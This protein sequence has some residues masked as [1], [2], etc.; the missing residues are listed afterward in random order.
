[1]S[2]ALIKESRLHVE[3]VQL[4]GQLKKQ[5]LLIQQLEEE[6]SRDSLTEL[7]TRENFMVAAQHQLATER[8]HGWSMLVF[9]D[10]RDFSTVN[11][12]YGHLV[13]NQIIA[14]IG[15]LLRSQIRLSDRDFHCRYGEKG[16]DEFCSLISNIDSPGTGEKLVRRFQDAIASVA[17]DTPKGKVRI[18][19]DIGAVC[20]WFDQRSRQWQH[21]PKIVAGLMSE[22]EQCMYSAKQQGKATKKMNPRFVI[23]EVRSG[24]IVSF[25]EQESTSN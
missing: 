11:N 2:S 20:V 4:K 23:R 14:D 12:E 18:E 7:I 21:I 24:K 25:E 10:I 8:R 13:G 16:G 1:M 22:T 6:V 3:I 17:W 15:K 5:E 19:I 9:S